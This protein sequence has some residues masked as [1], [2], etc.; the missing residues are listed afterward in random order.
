MEFRRK[1]KMGTIAGAAVLSWFSLV[2][3]LAEAT[4]P[5]PPP[6]AANPGQPAGSMSDQSLAGWLAAAAPM[7]GDLL[8]DV[9]LA[10]AI[11]TMNVA[12]AT[13]SSEARRQSALALAKQ[14]LAFAPHASRTWLLIAMLENGGS[15]SKEAAEALKM[16]YLTSSADPSLIPAR[17][18]VLATSASVD[19]AELANFARGDMRLI[20]THRPD[21][22]G[23]IVGAY[24]RGSPKG[25]A[26]LQD[27]ART[28]DPGLA[29]TLR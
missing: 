2:T 12:T 24:D 5:A 11:P 13:A 19:D 28:L 20:L 17:L 8:A 25:R 22:K 26:L 14:S 1:L 4:A 7:R 9:A 6:L 27:I 10:R 15:S 16:S 3:I 18:T 29:A 23:A 21:L